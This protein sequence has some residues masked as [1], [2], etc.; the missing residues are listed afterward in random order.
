MSEIKQN[1]EKV[2]TKIS[3]AAIKSGRNPEDVLL[4]VVTKTRSAEEVREAI[5]AGVTDIGENRAQE[6]IGKVPQISEDVNWHMIGHLQTNKINKVLPVVRMIQSVDSLKL[7]KNISKRCVRDGMTMDV[8]V[9]VNTSRESSKFG[10]NPTNA[11]N[12]VKE[13]QPL[14]GITIKGLMTVAEFLENPEQ[15]RPCFIELRRI[16]DEIADQNWE[17]ISMEHLSMGMTNDYE[18]AI[19]EGATIVR[20]GTAIFGPREY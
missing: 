14:A 7:A 17:G 1:L 9:E 6:L 3:E 19:E 18:V 20:I 11:L 15:V 13:M 12:V 5:D 8:L 2:R 16:R 4:V 10:I